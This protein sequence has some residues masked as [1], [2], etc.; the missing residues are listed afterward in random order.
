MRLGVYY[1]CGME[2]LFRRFVQE[3]GCLV[4]TGSRTKNGYGRIKID[5]RIV[6]THRVMWTLKRGP[7]P[8]GIEVLH[9]CDNPPCGN[10]EHLFLGTQVENM[11]DAAR[12]GRVHPGEAHGMAKLEEGAV[13]AI[14]SEAGSARAIAGRFGVSASTVK[15]IR[16]RRTWRHL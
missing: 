14:R 10:V 12:K 9:E 11:A 4:W 6:Y 15:D 3:N 2:R 5:G 13:L 7:I 1:T 16:A 8:E